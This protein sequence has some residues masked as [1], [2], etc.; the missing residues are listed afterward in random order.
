MARARERHHNI[1]FRPASCPNDSRLLRR[2]HTSVFGP[3]LS[4]S[5]SLVAMASARWDWCLLDLDP[6]RCHSQCFQFRCAGRL[7]NCH[8]RKH[9]PT[10]TW[11]GDF[12]LPPP[13]TCGSGKQTN[14]RPKTGRAVD[15]CSRHLIVRWSSFGFETKR[16]LRLSCATTTNETEPKKTR[17]SNLQLPQTQNSNSKQAN[18]GEHSQ[19]T[20]G[21]RS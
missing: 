21:A 20:S 3:A 15:S 16:N 18:A 4:S 8:P 13:P 11:N 17:N 19:S 2:R 14:E 5:L 1:P 7:I 10:C 6:H 12:V 9:P